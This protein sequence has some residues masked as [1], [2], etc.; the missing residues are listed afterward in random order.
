MLSFVRVAV[1]MLSVAVI[2][3]VDIV[4]LS[5]ILKLNTVLVRNFSA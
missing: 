5:V 4:M 3:N 1:V 2:L